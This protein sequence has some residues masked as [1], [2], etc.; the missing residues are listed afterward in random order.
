MGP[1]RIALHWRCSACNVAGGRRRN[2]SRNSGCG[3]DRE[4]S[5]AAALAKLRVAESPAKDPV[6]PRVPHAGHSMGA[7][8]GPESRAWANALK[9]STDQTAAGISALSKL[10]LAAKK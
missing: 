6:A 2:Q 10:F 8:T 1:A 5:R 3:G 7:G 9:P 4:H